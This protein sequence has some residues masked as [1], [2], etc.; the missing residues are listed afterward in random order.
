[1]LGELHPPENFWGNRHQ[2]SL[3]LSSVSTVHGSF[4]CMSLYTKNG[5][6]I[7][8]TSYKAGSTFRTMHTNGGDGLKEKER[9]EKDPGNP[10]SACMY[11][12]VADDT[13]DTSGTI[14]LCN[15]RS[16]RNFILSHFELLTFKRSNSLYQL[17]MI[18]ICFKWNGKQF[19]LMQI[20]VR[21][22]NGKYRVKLLSTVIWYYLTEMIYRSLCYRIMPYTFI[23]RFGLWVYLKLLAWVDQQSQVLSTLT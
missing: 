2:L 1:M 14:S 17:A 5:H 11:T 23:V 7:S 19:L 15:A 10:E 22:L 21:S 12:F 6:R 13:K 20:L 8:D 16:S 4:S 3:R 9:G 18:A